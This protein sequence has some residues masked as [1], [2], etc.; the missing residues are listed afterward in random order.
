MRNL[1]LFMLSSHTHTSI[2]E[3][4]GLRDVVS[5]TIMGSRNAG[6]RDYTSQ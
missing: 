3:G 1:V 2:A 4:I 6:N 5:V